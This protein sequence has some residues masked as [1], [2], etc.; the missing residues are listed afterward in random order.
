MAIEVVTKEHTE[1][2]AIDI[3][4]AMWPT[5]KFKAKLNAGTITIDWMG[6]PTPEQMERA[7]QTVFSP[8]SAFGLTSMI[9][10]RHCS[11]D[12]AQRVAEKLAEEYNLPRPEI[13]SQNEM[14]GGNEMIN[15][16]EGE[17]TLEELTKRICQITP[18]VPDAMMPKQLPAHAQAQQQQP[19]PQREQYTHYR[20]THYRAVR[21]A[22][23]AEAVGQQRDNHIKKYPKPNARSRKKIG[24]L[25]LTEQALYALADCWQRR[26]EGLPFRPPLLHNVSRRNQVEFLLKHEHYDPSKRFMHKTGIRTEA[27]YQEARQ[28]L[29]DLLKLPTPQQP[30]QP[31]QP[32][33]PE[34]QGQPE[35]PQG[36]S[37]QTLQEIEQ[38]LSQLNSI[39]Q[40][41]VRDALNSQTYEAWKDAAKIARE[42]AESPFRNA[43]E[44]ELFKKLAEYAKQQAEIKKPASAHDAERAE[45]ERLMQRIIQLA[46]LKP[47][48]DVLTVSK[49]VAQRVAQ[50]VQK[51]VT[52]INDLS[53]YTPS[54]SGHEVTRG[55]FDVILLSKLTNAF[56]GNIKRA[57]EDLAEGGRLIIFAES[58][59]TGIFGLK[60]WLEREV[61][62]FTTEK[63][64]KNI[65]LIIDK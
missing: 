8:A 12:F 10:S 52:S 45:V 22:R 3:L 16:A 33:Q 64:D 58:A 35:A 63:F 29:L 57:Y 21:L 62:Q 40:R 6:G 46:D 9:T 43:Q 11:I 39:M 48:M 2:H 31:Q 24:E 26:M 32:A 44:K 30:Q 60:T 41:D 42:R 14:I 19:T 59:V 25:T 47:G 23:L 38:S 18:A 7:L 50:L 34:P 55:K 53:I 15:T 65:L 17:M 61:M 36:P 13:I 49:Q 1:K 54:G 27:L 37:E 56:S 51:D 20:Y 28:A 4:S 5:V